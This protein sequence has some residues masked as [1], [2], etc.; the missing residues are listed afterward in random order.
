MRTSSTR[1]QSAVEYVFL[2]AGGL[3]FVMLAIIILRGGIFGESPKR[4]NETTNSFIT[5]YGHNYLC[6]D[7]FDAET[8]DRYT[9]YSGA[10][11]FNDRKLTAD[12]AQEGLLMGD[13]HLGN[14]SLSVKVKRAAVGSAGIV[15]RALNSTSS[16]NL[17][18]DSGG[19]V[20]IT[21]SPDNSLVNS[22]TLPVGVTLANG[23][24]VRLDVYDHDFSVYVN[25]AAVPGLSPVSD[26]TYIAGL[27]GFYSSA[28]GAGYSEFDDF[29]AC[30]APCQS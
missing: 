26:S 7:N 30:E 9:V 16:Y 17:T 12:A 28:G 8:L 22:G 5:N 15:F 27:A 18:V 3:L 1:S 2:V 6:F 13:C 21:V 10:W 24:T 19:S 29:M 11:R 14:F 20:K 25:G 23:F 4:I